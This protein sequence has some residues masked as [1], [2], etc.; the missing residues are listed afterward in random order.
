LSK[1]DLTYVTTD[2]LTEGVGSSQI[3][4]LILKLNKQGLKVNLI[5][6]EKIRPSHELKSKLSHVNVNWTPLDF[7]LRFGVGPI[8]R[9]F[10]L[11]NIIM[12]SEIIHARSDIPAMASILSGQG[13]VL[14][15]V[16]SLWTDQRIFNSKT[17]LQK[18]LLE[19]MRFIE[20]FN[21]A[22]S[23]GMS[24]L[25]HKIIPELT[26]RYEHLPDLR[27]VV[28]TFVDLERFTKV[29]IIPKHIK[30][31]YSG[32][33]NKYYDL[34]LSKS[35]TDHLS[36]KVPIEIHW[37]RP[38]ETHQTHLGVGETKT[39]ESTQNDMASILGSYSFGMS[40]CRND[41]GPSLKAA[42]PTKIAEFLAAG[43]PVVVNKGLGDFDEFLKEFNAGVILDGTSGNLEEGTEKLL[44]LILDPETPSRC[45]ALAEKY[46]DLNQGVTKYLR[47]YDL[48]KRKI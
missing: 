29:P 43:R 5:S 25:T 3:L 27:I 11:K 41:A 8:N 13:P 39:F 26:Q 16:R 7:Q 23:S 31:L 12:S 22:R 4:P 30:A 1:F 9:V 20:R 35:F 28:P 38:A 17:K 46:F 14:W 33:F 42:M 34:V 19:P 36:T 2:S 15:D 48:M 47:L 18:M 45:R 24:T 10:E 32:T 40:V 21:C 44:T 37:A 6:Y